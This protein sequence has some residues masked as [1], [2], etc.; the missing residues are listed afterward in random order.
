VE[1]DPF[2]SASA[3]REV[4]QQAV[5][6]ANQFAQT[7]DEFLTRIGEGADLPTGSQAEINSLR[8]LQ[9][10]MVTLAGRLHVASEALNA[11]EVVAEAWRAVGDA[12]SGLG[13]GEAGDGTA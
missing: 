5:R 1:G 11:P 13:A 2:E 3:T 7:A 10:E 8:L 4:I 12:E 9:V 6:C